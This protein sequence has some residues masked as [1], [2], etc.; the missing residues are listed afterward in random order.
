MNKKERL[1]AAIAHEAVDRSPVSLWKHFPV[2]D[3]YPETHTE[4]TLAFQRDYDFDFIKISPSDEYMIHDYGTQT[5]WTADL[6]G[7]RT[8]TQRAIFKPQDWRALKPLDPQTGYM[9]QFLKTLTLIQKNVAEET[10][11]IATLFSPLK[12]GIE[13]AGANVFFEHLHHYPE[14]VLAGLKVLTQNTV[15]FAQA[16][17][18][19]G[20]AGFF[21]ALEHANYV[22]FDRA[23]YNKFV[24]VFDLQILHS[25]EDLWLNVLHL[26]G[27]ALIFDLAFTYPAQVIQW[28]S[29]ETGPTFEEV[30]D[31]IKGAVLG[32]LQRKST[33]L[34]GTPEEVRAEALAT[35]KTFNNRGIILGAG[36]MLEQ[37]VPRANIRAARQ[38]VEESFAE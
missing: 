16:A 28:H 10:P 20:V 27:P 4:A 32:G 17:R 35:L 9:G 24:E 15:N 31:K 37:H 38:S 2:D 19:T 26:H 29:R 3:Q 25:V 13:L 6:R 7:C 22:L 30:K 18:T 12:Q 14:D 11:Y 8:Y 5:E 23:G 1:K 33:L 34:T 21:Y 36:C